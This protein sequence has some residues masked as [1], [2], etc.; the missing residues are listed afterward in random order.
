MAG[1]RLPRRTRA[2]A[3]LA[4]C[5][6]AVVPAAA[7]DPLPTCYADPCVE[8]DAA[9]GSGGADA[10]AAV[11]S[12]NGVSVGLHAGPDAA[13]LFYGVG[14]TRCATGVV[15]DPPDLAFLCAL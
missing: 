11:K 8:E 7:A 1:P 4:L 13:L 14:V 12:P 2:I 15:P 9:V 6:L 5:L 10:S 3:V